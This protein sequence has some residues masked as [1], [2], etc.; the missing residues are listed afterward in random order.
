MQKTFIDCNCEIACPYSTT[1]CQVPTEVIMHEG[2][3]GID[4][5]IF[6]MGA[7]KDEEKQKRCF[8]GRSG[9]YMRS[10]IKHI[11]DQRSVFNLAISNN[12]RFHPMDENGKDREPTPIEISRCV[13]ILLNDIANLNPKVIIPVGKNALS[14]LIDIGSSPMKDLR[15]HLYEVTLQGR[16]YHVLPTWHPSYLTRQYG[17]FIPYTMNQHDNEFISDILRALGTQH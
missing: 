4:I 17:K 12:V 6:G 2:R 3:S 5:F 13:R 7:G 8:V 1:C 11:W 14:T 16:E 15:G 9:K 10:I